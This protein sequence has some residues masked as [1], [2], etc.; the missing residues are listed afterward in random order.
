MKFNK[1]ISNLEKKMPIKKRVPPGENQV[2]VY[3][4]DDQE[5]KISEKLA[6]LRN[7]YGQEVSMGDLLIIMIDYT[8]K[9]VMD[10]DR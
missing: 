10:P 7:K 6:E 4:T 1:R 8:Q 3:P 5:T 9:K 2:V